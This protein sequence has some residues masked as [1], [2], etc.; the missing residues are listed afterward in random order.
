MK[1]STTQSAAAVA[2]AA[3]KA[4]PPRASSSRPASAAAGTLAQTM[5]PRASTQER[6]LRRGE[7]SRSRWLGSTLAG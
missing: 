4:L 5:P 1:G 3:S 6:S 7:S 2:M